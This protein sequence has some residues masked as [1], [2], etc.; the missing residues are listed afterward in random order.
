MTTLAPPLPRTAFRP[1]LPVL[2]AATGVLYLWGLGASGWANAYYSAA[3]QAG[4]ASWKALLFGATDA[5]GGITVD[6]TPASVW[7]MGLSARIFGVHS[8][9]ILVPQALMG[10]ATVWLLYAAVKRVAGEA[11]ALLAGIVLALT[12]VAVL[13]F[14]FNNPDAL[15]VLLLTAGAYATVRAIE[16]ANRRGRVWWLVLA[17]ACVGF[18]F[19]TKMLQAFLVLPA[20]GLAWLVGARRERLL[21]LAVAAGAVI[22]SAGWWVLL[23]TLWP[24]ADR[25]YIGGSQHNSVLE[26]TFGYNGFGRLTGDEVGSVG[27]GGTGGVWGRLFG[28]EMAGGIAWLLPAA[29]VLLAGGL[30]ATWRRGPVWT[31]LLLWGGWLVVTAVV[32]SLMDGIIHAYYTVALAPALAGVLG[33][34]VVALWRKGFTGV[35]VLSGAV[36]LTAMETYLLLE[37]LVLLVLG[38]AAAALLLLVER[39]LAVAALAVVI[40]LAGP[41]AYS[42]QTA[43]ATHSGALPSAGPSVGP[44]VG[45]MN[46]GG[47]GGLLD[48]PTPGAD[49]V[50]LLR[51][52]DHTWAAATVGSNNAA[53]YQLGSGKPVLAVGGFNGTDPSPTL[54]Q[55]QE[56]VRRGQIHWFIGDGAMSSTATGGSDAGARIAEWVA[57]NFEAQQVSGVAVYDLS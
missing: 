21:G 2:L 24:A 57:E 16:D 30:W 54:A 43:A 36:A 40:A 32:F 5:A 22:V 3:A 6:K 48:A 41:A 55:F 9:S 20:F 12:P 7:V 29:V 8:W 14:R 33:I 50:A 51:Q 47:M 17:G 28:A 4:A 44:P 35:A 37:S 13:M 23:V 15:L 18:G 38:L 25:P 56:Y 45:N 11:A 1:L 34:G 42:L 27:G 31:S 19:L 46:F 26:L 49:L 39:S 53:G 10:V 52:G